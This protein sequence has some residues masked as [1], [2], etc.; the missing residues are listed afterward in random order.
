M[1]GAPEV[2]PQPGAR[3]LLRRGG[4]CYAVPA[5]LGRR[6][7]AGERVP[8]LE[9]ALDAAAEEPRLPGGRPV[10]L[11]VPV[12]PGRVVAWAARA[13]AGLASWRALAWSTAFGAAGYLAT[14]NAGASGVAGLDWPRLV[15]GM[16]GAG[17]VHELG[18][19]AALAR[20]GGR[21]GP[22]GLG[23]LLVFPVLYCDVTAG[24]LLPRRERLRV[25]VAG[26][27]WHLG[28]G[29]ARAMAGAARGDPTTTL[30]A[31]G[32]LAS[33]IWS[34]L[35]FLRTDGHWLL[36]DWLGVRSLEEPTVEGASRGL[37][38]ALII[39][40]VGYLV[41]LGLVVVLLGGRG[42]WLAEKTEGWPSTVRT[43]ALVLAVCV[44]ILGGI[45]LAKR[46][47]ALGKGIL[48]DA[49]HL[50]ESDNA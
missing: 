35:P 30:V 18:H 44:S 34:L 29:G 23:L 9:S 28:I 27:A 46:G 37:R 48:S 26:V 1:K 5:E 22:I 49:G 16:L 3:W 41:F 20:G 40:R 47:W 24:A 13:M 50:V 25:D 8:G 6:L 21:P 2:V 19:A 38:V 4:R 31:W 11:R 36:C 33:V 12:L 7:S 43:M 42:Y 32:V 14:L 39:W 17:L 45:N 10:W 15:A